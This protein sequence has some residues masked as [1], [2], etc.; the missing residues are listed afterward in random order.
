MAKI[1][2]QSPEKK[3]SLLDYLVLFLLLSFCA[4]GILT[5]LLTLF[6]IPLV[7]GGDSTVSEL[8]ALNHTAGFTLAAATQISGVQQMSDS[9][10]V[11]TL[12][13]QTPPLQ[14]DD[15]LSI[16][17]SDGKKVLSETDCLAGYLENDNYVGRTLIRCN[18]TVP[19]NYV[20]QNSVDFRA[21]LEPL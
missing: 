3:N 17:A 2:T 11:V 12:L 19:Y 13:I 4:F 8:V 16:I 10:A 6:G 9:P 18:A 14:K 5:S 21:R 15:S 1:F 7:T 20:S